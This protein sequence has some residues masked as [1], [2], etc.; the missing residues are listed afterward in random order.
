MQFQVI[1][2]NYNNWFLSGKGSIFMYD[3]AL[4]F[5][6]NKAKFI[7]PFIENY[8][9]LLFIQTTRTVPYSTI[10]QYRKSKKV[11]GYHQIVYRL[12]NGK[13]IKIEFKMTNEHR[14]ENNI[15]F[16]TKLEEYL[17]VVNNFAVK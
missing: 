3:T 16:A 12:S 7:I 10:L 9:Q 8:F 4:V 14:K 15:S 6:G 1:Y 17:V 5:K 13:K 2:Y 11:N